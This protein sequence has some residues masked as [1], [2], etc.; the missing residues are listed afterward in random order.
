MTVAEKAP[1]AID[2]KAA[3]APWYRRWL[4]LIGVAVIVLYCLVPFFW[5]VVS[6]LRRPTDQ[7]D[8]SVIPSPIS[9]T[10][11]TDVFGDAVQRKPKKKNGR[12]GPGPAKQADPGAP[13]AGLTAGGGLGGE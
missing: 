4:P 11:F 6:S 5:M 8:N 13:V 1:R 2:I 10:N 3:E 7:F 12:N 9:F